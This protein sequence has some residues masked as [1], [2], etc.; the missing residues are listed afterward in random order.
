[1][2]GK[3][4]KCDVCERQEFINDFFVDRETFFDA[5]FEGWIRLTV[6]KPRDYGWSFRDPKFATTVNSVDCCSLD[7]ARKYLYTV[8][9][10]VPEDAPVEETV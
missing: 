1:M 7:C 4:V 5:G 3:S 6:N 8:Q 10:T 2:Y 9:A